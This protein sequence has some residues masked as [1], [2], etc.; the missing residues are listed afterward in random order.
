MPGPGEVALRRR[1]GTSTWP[2]TILRYS[3]CNSLNGQVFCTTAETQETKHRQLPRPLTQRDVPA[4]V[5]A[6]SVYGATGE[7]P[8]DWHVPHRHHDPGDHDH[9]HGEGCG[10]RAVP[11]DDHVDYLHDGHWHAPHEGHYDEHID[12]DG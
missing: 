5:T 6:P 8:M 10:H 7:V 1:R 12:L 3:H 4:L 2:R 11:H 9:V